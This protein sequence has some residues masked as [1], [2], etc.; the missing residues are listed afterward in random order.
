[1]VARLGKCPKN[2]FFCVFGLLSYKYNLNQVRLEFRQLF[3]ILVHPSPYC[4]LERLK[5][6]EWKEQSNLLDQSD[7]KDDLCVILCTPLVSL[8]RPWSVWV[9]NSL[10]HFG[11]IVSKCWTSGLAQN[12]LEHFRTIVSKCWTCLNVERL[13]VE[14]W[15]LL[16][17]VSFPRVESNWKED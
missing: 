1:M 6:R 2:H 13:N 15:V 3:D 14:C 7:G 17:Q 12:S 10:E 4:H 11:T 9:H 5:Q 16:H 8:L